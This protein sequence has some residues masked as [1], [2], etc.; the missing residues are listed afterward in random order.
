MLLETSIKSNNEKY[1]NKYC[2]MSDNQTR[3]MGIILEVADFVVRHL[4]FKP[5]TS[6]FGGS[7][8]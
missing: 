4:G 1:S 3:T 2:Y 7:L 5:T 8:Y 6:F